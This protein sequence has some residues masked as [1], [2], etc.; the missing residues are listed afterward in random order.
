[1]VDQMSQW[2]LS[3][4][5]S[6]IGSFD[7]TWSKCSR[8]TDPDPDPDHLK[9]THPKCYMSKKRAYIV[10]ST[11]VSSDYRSIMVST[12]ATS[13]KSTIS[14]HKASACTICKMWVRLPSLTLARTRSHT[15]TAVQGGGEGRSWNPSLE[16]S[17]CCSISKRFHLQWKVLIFLTRWAIFYGWWL[18]WKSA[19]SQNMVAVLEAILNF[20]QN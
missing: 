9:G 18:C 6:L 4:V 13:S 3:K 17:I 14:C 1:M 7:L 12:E 10:P 19:T 11:I 8:I 2:I 5:D 16:F 15:P 20:A